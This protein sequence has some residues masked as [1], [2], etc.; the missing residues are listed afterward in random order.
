MTVIAFFNFSKN[1]LLDEPI[2]WIIQM[3]VAN[4]PTNIT[5]KKKD[6]VTTSL[7]L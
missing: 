7:I 6:M 4:N 2:H 1:S 5:T 3:I